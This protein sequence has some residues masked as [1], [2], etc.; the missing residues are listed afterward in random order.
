MKIAMV[1]HTVTAVVAAGFLTVLAGSGHA[2]FVLYDD[3]SSGIIGPGKWSGFTGEGPFDSPTTELI[4]TVEGGQLHLS[5]VSYG[6]NTSD[7]GSPS[8]GQGLNMRQLGVPGGTGF[9]TGIKAR[10]TVLDAVAQ[11][12]LANSNPQNTSPRVQLNGSFFNDGSST[13]VNDRT[14]D[15]H[16]FLIIVKD[17]SGANRIIAGIQ[18][19][20]NA[21]CNPIANLGGT[22]FATTWAVNV[23]VT[24]KLLWQKDQGMFRFVANGEVK[25]IFYP[26]GITEGGPPVLD[27]KQ[28]W[29]LNFVENCT[30]GRKKGSI[31]ALIDDVQVRRQP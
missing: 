1:R 11:G 22:Q 9:I 29:L 25:D 4:R 30:E 19:C 13:G 16:V 15:I 6:A 21:S 26:V 3:F 5:L 23:P 14:G 27:S 2:Q 31:D 8:S 24:V 7:T 18:R 20:Q 28:V 12:C 17:A 10:V